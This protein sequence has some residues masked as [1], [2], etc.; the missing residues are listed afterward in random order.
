MDMKLKRMLAAVPAFT[1]EIF[2]TLIGSW[3]G[4]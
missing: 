2:E 1:R 4:V 3:E